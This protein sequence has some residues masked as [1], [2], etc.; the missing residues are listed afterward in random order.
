M[1]HITKKISI[2]SKQNPT[3]ALEQISAGVAL[4][5][6]IKQTLGPYGKN[7]L[8]EKGLRITNDGRKI[9]SELQGKNEI[10]DLAL[11]TLRDAMTK[12]NDLLEDGST[13][14]ATM[15]EAIYNEFVK[16]LPG[17]QLSGKYSALTLRK[18]IALEL[19]FITA[20]LK[21]QVVEIKSEEDLVG[22]A[23]TSVED[24][25]LA[26]LIAKTQWKL[27][28]NGFILV[29]EHNAPDDLMEEINGIRIDNGFATSNAINNL[30]K[31]RLEL[32]DI[33]ILL[34]NHTIND[35][36]EMRDFLSTVHNKQNIKEFALMARAF[37]SQA[38]KQMEEE[39]RSGF[40]IMPLNAP[41]VNQK[42]VMKDLVAVFGGVYIDQEEMS[43]DSIVSSH[44]G[45][46]KKIIAE[47]WSAVYTGEKDKRAKDRIAERIVELEKILKGTPSIFEQKNIKVRIS[48]LKNG[49]A[50]LKIGA[51]TENERKYRFDK[52][53]DCVGAVR[54]A[55]Q[56]G[57]VPGAGIGYKIV[58]DSLEDDFILKKPLLAP[59]T[60]IMVNAGEPF[61]VEPWVKNAFKVER[62]VLENATQ[63][64]FNMATAYGASSNAWPKKKFNKDDFEDEE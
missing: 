56:E 10:Q 18:K 59:Y 22:V 5:G 57:V 31:Q 49:F 39:N 28:E 43:L 7:F 60:E 3:E 64:A 12:T 27:G 15:V 17:K 30:E 52:A 48:Q 16:L 2:N 26:K 41:Y 33:P 32:K 8:I 25:E 35:I 47:R 14:F 6:S 9:A 24:E 11:R 1:A 40:R 55:L 50:I 23:K 54:H 13:S 19:Q 53:E 58:S 45:F 63:T 36:Y 37:S 62:V 46:A 21:E 34:T 51:L 29:E 42:E 4:L 61:E 20:K 44:L 38:I